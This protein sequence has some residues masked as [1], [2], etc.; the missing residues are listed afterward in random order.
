MSFGER[1]QYGARV[2]DLADIEAIL[3]VFKAYGYGEVDTSRKYCGGTSEEYL[4]RLAK[5][6]LKL[7]TKLYPYPNLRKH[8]LL[9]MRALDATQL[10]IWYL[11]APDRTTPYEVTLRAVNELYKEGHFKRFGISKYMAFYMQG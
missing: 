6:G 7:E 5:Q 9:S 1:G 2:H 4:G 10:E 3:D 11:H 8:L